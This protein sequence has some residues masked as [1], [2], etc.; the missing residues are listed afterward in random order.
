MQ[1]PLSWRWA[2]VP[3]GSVEKVQGG[4]GP[5]WG[6]EGQSGHTSPSPPPGAGTITGHGQRSCL[7]NSL[8]PRRATLP[9]AGRWGVA[10]TVVREATKG[11]GDTLTKEGAAIGTAFKPWRVQVS[12][13]K[14]KTLRLEGLGITS[15]IKLGCGSHLRYW[16]CFPCTLRSN[17]GADQHFQPNPHLQ[18][19]CKGSVWDTK[20]IL[21]PWSTLQGEGDFFPCFFPPHHLPR[22]LVSSKFCW[23]K[24]FSVPQTEYFTLQCVTLLDSAAPV[25]AFQIPWCVYTSSFCWERWV[26]SQQGCWDARMSQLLAGRWAPH[27]LATHTFWSGQ[28]LI[29]LSLALEMREFYRSSVFLGPDWS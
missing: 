23:P 1:K 12:G 8:C 26:M 27:A 22:N 29:T 28:V 17:R 16:S 9:A 25:S 15:E 19:S 18:D 2:Q 3:R 13:R 5:F 6:C 21:H 4:E 20:R 10:G 11:L 14:F 7:R 24:P